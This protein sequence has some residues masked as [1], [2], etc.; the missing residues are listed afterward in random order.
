ML[1]ISFPIGSHFPTG[2]RLV[3]PGR[4]ARHEVNHE[5]EPVPLGESK[6]SVNYP[7]F[8]P[9]VATVA[10]FVTEPVFTGVASGKT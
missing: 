7:R 1:T 5:L 6:Y 10:S 3:E 8:S 4:S 9:D 2:D